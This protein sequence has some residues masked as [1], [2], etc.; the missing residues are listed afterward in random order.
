MNHIIQI[1]AND[2][3]NGIFYEPMSNTRVAIV[4]YS[5]GEVMFLW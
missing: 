3:Q 5:V 1:T 2:R 4:Y